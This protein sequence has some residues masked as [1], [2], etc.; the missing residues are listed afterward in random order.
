VRVE[1]RRHAGVEAHRVDAD[2][3]VPPLQQPLDGVGMNTSAPWRISP[4]AAL[5]T[6]QVPHLDRRVRVVGHALRDVDHH[7]GREQLVRAQARGRASR[8]R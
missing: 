3:D 8:R 2:A 4:V 5:E 1:G 7:G 6:A